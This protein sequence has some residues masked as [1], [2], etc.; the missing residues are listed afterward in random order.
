MARY[1]DAELLNPEDFENCTRYQAQ[2]IINEIPTAD[3]VP[4]SD[5]EQLKAMYEDNETQ[6]AYT[7][8]MLGERL[9]L[10]KNEVAREIF[11]EIEYNFAEIRKIEYANPPVGVMFNTL[12]YLKKKYTEEKE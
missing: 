7:I 9:E 11:V 4:K 6:R 5:Y 8:N 12:D 1:I 3:V 2:G 10:Q